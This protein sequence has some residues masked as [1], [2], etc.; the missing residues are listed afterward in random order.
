VSYTNTGLF[1]GTSNL[2]F[3]ARPSGAHYNGSIDDTRIYDRALTPEEISDIY[4]SNDLANDV[5]QSNANR[6]NFEEG[7]GTTTLG[8]AIIPLDM[9]QVEFD[10][11]D[12]YINLGSSIDYSTYAFSFWINKNDIS[13]TE[14]V[15]SS[16]EYLLRFEGNF[17]KYFPAVSSTGVSIFNTVPSGF[18]ANQWHHFVLNYDETSGAYSLYMDNSLVTS[19]T[20]SQVK[21]AVGNLYL[22]GTS[23]FLDGSMDEV[24]IYDRALSSTEIELLYNESPYNK[25]CDDCNTTNVNLYNLTEGNYNIS[26]L[27]IAEA[28]IASL[29]QNFNIDLTNPVINDTLPSEINSYLLNISEYVTCVESNLKTCNITFT[30]DGNTVLVNQTSL[31]NFTYNGNQSYNI[32]AEDQAGNKVSESGTILVNPFAHFQFNNSGTLLNNYTFGG[33]LWANET[34]KFTLYNSI[35]NMSANN[36]IEFNKVGYITQTFTQEVLNT[37]RINTSY[38]VAEAEIIVT[39]R[40]KDTLSQITGTNFTLS[41][42]GNTGFTTTTITGNKTITGLLSAGDYELIVSSTPY[43][44]ESNF[45]TFSN[46]E[47]LELTVYLANSSTNGFV[48]IEATGTSGELAVSAKVQALQ[49]NGV[50]YIVVSEGT[51]DTSGKA[52]LNVIL[53]TKSYQFKLIEGTN[54]ITSP[55]ETITT[56]ENGKTVPLSLQ[57]GGITYNAIIDNYLI[58]STET[59][60]NQ[61]NISSILMDWNS[62]DGTDMVACINVYTLLN[63]VERL[64]NS[65][66]SNAS[67]SGQMN[68]N[69][70]INSSQFTNI[71]TELLLSNSYYTYQSYKYTPTLSFQNALLTYGFYFFVMLILY[72]VSIWA[73]MTLFDNIYIALMLVIVSG[74]IGY[75]LVPSVI[76]NLVATSFGLMGSLTIWA[77]Y[78]KK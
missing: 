12:D 47:L 37:S 7:S 57:T 61:T 36:T 78:K 58:N 1:K 46:Q 71:K 22:S 20:N 48:I 5:R 42:I 8:Q 54:S 51:T 59:Y 56:D 18:G 14:N 50:N 73:G 23:N 49:W 28:N 74:F 3:G 27:A 17:I 75:S 63:D 67:S 16:N 38:N 30:P 19:G 76:T 60:N 21:G 40:D 10:G 43:T 52:T 29:K 65:F 44:T 62:R 11:I 77:G 53:K 25:L 55:A 4:T 45:F 13:G 70:L 39:I 68:K 33:V 2:Q 69:F 64:S 72:L 15:F 24:R 66:C 26:F 6:F 31:Y 41:F 34:A 35:L 32:I 9:Q